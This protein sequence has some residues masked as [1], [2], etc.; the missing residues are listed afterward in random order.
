MK[1]KP[2]RWCRDLYKG[3][4]WTNGDLIGCGIACLTLFQIPHPY[5][6]VDRA[7]PLSPC[8]WSIKWPIVTHQFFL[9]LLLFVQSS[10]FFITKIMAT[11]Q[12]LS[13]THTISPLA[14]CT[15]DASYNAM[16][17]EGP[18][19]FAFARIKGE[20]CLVQGTPTVSFMRHYCGSR[21]CSQCRTLHR[22]PH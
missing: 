15:P 21:C 20:V 17:N 12:L 1:R 4:S 14:K 6:L 13:H 11:A 22:P 3:F 8:H 9:P 10:G 7:C 2:R 16:H 5:P 19:Y 18:G